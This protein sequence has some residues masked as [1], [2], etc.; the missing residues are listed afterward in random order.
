M[1]ADASDRSPHISVIGNSRVTILAIQR[2]VL[3]DE[4]GSRELMTLK[5]IRNV[6]GLIRV[7]SRAIGTELCFVNVRMTRVAPLAQSF[8]LESIVT[9]SARNGF[10]LSLENEP[11]LVVI[12]FRV[13]PHTPRIGGMARLARHF[14]IAV[15]GSLGTKGKNSQ[16]HQRHKES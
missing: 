12:E 14:D 8:K 7:T 2:G 13:G 11:R 16:D 4:R 5:H 15:R 10:V 3:S 1:T 9:A 6:P